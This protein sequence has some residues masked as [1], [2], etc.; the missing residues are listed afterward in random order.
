[1]WASKVRKCHRVRQ[2]IDICVQQERSNRV[3]DI[4]WVKNLFSFQLTLAYGFAAW[5]RHFERSMWQG[6]L[7]VRYMKYCPKTFLLSRALRGRPFVTYLVKRKK[8]TLLGFSR[9]C[10]NNKEA[11][12]WQEPILIDSCGVSGSV[13]MHAY[14]LS[15]SAFAANQSL[16]HVF[17][18]FLTKTLWLLS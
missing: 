2:Q 17:D 4:L 10:Y 7:D 13:I 18:R 5:I 8:L 11:N 16:K 3:Y 12:Q 15:L 6:Q 9:R 1:M 14:S